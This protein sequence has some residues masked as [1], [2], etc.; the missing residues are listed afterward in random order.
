MSHLLLKAKDS[1]QTIM[2]DLNTAEF[3]L[4]ENTELNLEKIKAKDFYLL[5]IINSDSPTCS[6]ILKI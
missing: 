2:E 1:S 6:L 3:P 4:N 5:F